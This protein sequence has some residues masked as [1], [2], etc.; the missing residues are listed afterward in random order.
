[1]NGIKI[2]VMDVDGVLT[3]GRIVLDDKGVEYKFFD[4]K[5]G[6]IIHIALEAGLKIAWISGRYS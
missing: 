4:V 2:V 6:H 1:M 5:D 3:D